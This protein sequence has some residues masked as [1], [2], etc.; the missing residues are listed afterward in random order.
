MQEQRKLL[1]VMFVCVLYHEQKNKSESKFNE[2][3][4]EENMGIENKKMGWQTNTNT[5]AP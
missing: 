5:H 1:A 4:D 2:E 3:I